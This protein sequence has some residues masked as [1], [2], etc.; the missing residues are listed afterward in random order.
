[1]HSPREMGCGHAAL[2]TQSL[3]NLEGSTGPWKVDHIPTL[4]TTTTTAFRRRDQSDKTGDA[5]A[6]SR[7]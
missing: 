4:G 6:W 1:M 3:D 5:T 7:V 2:L